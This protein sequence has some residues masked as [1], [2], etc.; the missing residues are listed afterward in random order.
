MDRLLK[1]MGLQRIPK[2][3]AIVIND[4]AYFHFGDKATVL[5]GT[6]VKVHP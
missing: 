2:G 3:R 6:I 1:L 4:D 5:N